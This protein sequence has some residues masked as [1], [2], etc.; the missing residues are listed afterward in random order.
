MTAMWCIIYPF[1]IPSADSAWKPLD[2]KGTGTP[3]RMERAMR[4]IAKEMAELARERGVGM[5]EAELRA[6]GF[7]KDEITQHATEAAEMLRAAE[8][9][10]AA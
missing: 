3:K 7:T 9:A 8:T 10:R 6:E 2:D 1:S 5:T 4:N